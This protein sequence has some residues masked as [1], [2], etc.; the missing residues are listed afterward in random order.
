ML[1]FYVRIDWW[2][3]K[4]ALADLRTRGDPGLCKLRT[5]ALLRSY[6]S[7]WMVMVLPGR[8]PSSSEL[9]S[10]HLGLLFLPT[11]SGIVFY[12]KESMLC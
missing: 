2:N 7:N 5:Q 8:H 6:Q 1:F 9:S 12:F 3:R 10:M 4:C 11:H